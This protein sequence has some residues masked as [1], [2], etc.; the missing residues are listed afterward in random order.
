MTP[1]EASGGGAWQEGWRDEPVVSV[2]GS[3]RKSATSSTAKG[4]VKSRTTAER[5]DGQAPSSCASAGEA[6]RST[7]LSASVASSLAPTPA[8]PI[9][10]PASGPSFAEVPRLHLD[11]KVWSPSQTVDFLRCPQLWQYKQRWEDRAGNA[12][13]P[14]R[15]MGTAVDGGLTTL[16]ASIRGGI[17]WR[18]AVPEGADTVAHTLHLH[19]P[20]DASPEHEPEA[21]KRIALRAYHRVVEERFAEGHAILGTQISWG[22][23]IADMVTLTPEDEL[24]IWD[25]KFS[26]ELRPEWFRARLEDARL[27]WPFYHYAWR[28]QQSTGKRV[29][30]AVKVVISGTPRAEVKTADVDMDKV[31]LDNW[32]RSAASAWRTMTHMRDGGQKPFMNWNGCKLFGGCYFFTACHSL[33]GDE[34]RFEALGHI[35]KGQR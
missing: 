14:A 26:Y 22:E 16:Y 3:R 23:S 35:R 34:D 1:T 2:K 13:T 10:L 27:T 6:P 4:K 19:W 32:L 21:A 28:A 20:L 17:E 29:R 31:V 33:G 30:K 7:S 5:V 25:W 24:V 11:S 18:L 8:S 9:F 15:V 12:W